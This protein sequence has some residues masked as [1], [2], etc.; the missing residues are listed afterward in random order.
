MS[1]IIASFPQA[2]F[3]QQSG[4]ANYEVSAAVQGAHAA[5]CELGEAHPRIVD[6][7]RIV[8]QA[9]VSVGFFIRLLGS[10]GSVVI[11]DVNVR[12]R[13]PVDFRAFHQR[14]LPE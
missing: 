8:E 1:D 3:G 2:P 9:L 7:L 4:K 11:C 14:L 12:R 6:T 5:R 10:L 13:T